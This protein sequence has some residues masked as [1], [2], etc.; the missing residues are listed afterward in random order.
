MASI[1]EQTT[2]PTRARF[3]VRWR[4]ADGSARSESFTTKSAAR[5]K[6]REVE[7]T[8]ADGTYVD[9]REGRTTVEAW[10]AIAAEGWVDLAPS[11]RD[12]YAVILESQ[13]LPNLGGRALRDVTAG[14]IQKLVT[15]LSRT[16]SASTVRKVV[17]VLR[18]LF[19]DAIVARKLAVSPCVGIR[20]PKLAPKVPETLTRKELDKLADAL[21]DEYRAFA[22]VTGR[23]GLR[24][25]EALALRWRDVDLDAVRPTVTVRGSIVESGGI[26]RESTPKTRAGIRS[27]PISAD[28][29]EELRD[30]R[31]WTAPDAR[32][33]VFPA[34]E[35]G[36]YRPGNFRNRVFAPAVER[37]GL[38]I[39]PH[40]LRH[41]ALTAWLENGATPMLAAAWAG[42]A[43]GGALIVRTYGH[44]LTAHA[45]Q[46]LDAMNGA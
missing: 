6:L 38:S 3:K 29:V 35:G 27:V 21:P 45:D 26:L 18:R 28:V 43:D 2:D 44:V 20:L 17:Y 37:V 34:A 25:G 46:V 41:A 10:S 15:K 7:T 9:D 32:S 1:S 22:Y 16:L 39:T 36:Y 12:R 33:L 40:A 30:L 19:D 42:H 24:I 23:L 31:D 4:E 8:V 5:A 11:T 13:I 14:E